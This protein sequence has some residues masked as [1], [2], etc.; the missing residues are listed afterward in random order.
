M[1]RVSVKIFDLFARYGIHLLRKR[2]PDER[3]LE[4]NSHSDFLEIGCGD[5]QLELGY[6]LLGNT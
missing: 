4:R 6:Q 2:I 3:E 1:F 5:D